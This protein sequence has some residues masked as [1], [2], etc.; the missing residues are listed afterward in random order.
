M[1]YSAIFYEVF[2]H[3]FP[4]LV[5]EDVIIRQ[6]LIFLRGQQKGS[7]SIQD[8]SC[9]FDLNTSMSYF[10]TLKT[11]SFWRHASNIIHSLHINQL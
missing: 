1:S 3:I 10:V 5:N 7:L 4:C 9:S 2:L 11:P 8:L 6:I